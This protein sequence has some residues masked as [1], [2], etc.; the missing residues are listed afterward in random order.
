MHQGGKVV[1]PSRNLI[2]LIDD[3]PEVLRSLERALRQE[4][5]EIV[6]TSSPSEVLRLI[7]ERSVDLIISDQR[8]PEMNGTDLLEVVRDYS[9]DT[10]CVILTAFPDTAVVLQES[11]LRL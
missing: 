5:Y 9:P 3:E 7:C 2:V 1:G 11:G 10:A 8:M 4:P 6:S